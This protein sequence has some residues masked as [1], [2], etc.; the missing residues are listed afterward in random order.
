[1]LHTPTAIK[2]RDNTRRS[3]Y[4]R[5]LQFYRGDQWAAIGGSTTLAT[6]RMQR[7]RLVHNYARAFITKA[8]AYT[9]HDVR[10][11]VDAIDAGDAGNAAATSAEVALAQVAE[12]NA[13]DIL[14]LDNEISCCVLG[15]AAYKVTWSQ[16]EQRVIVTAPSVHALSVWRRADNWFQIDRV[17]QASQLSAY[18][19]LA[20]YGDLASPA[21]KS[22]YIEEWT[23][24]EYVLWVNGEAQRFPNPYGFIPFVVYPNI[25]EPGRE[26]GTSDIPAVRVPGEEYNRVMT[27]LSLIAELSGNPIAVLEGITEDTDIAIQPGAVWD[28]PAGAKAYI[29]DL[30]AAGGVRLLIDYAAE[31]KSIM[32]DLG[33]SPPAAFGQNSRG[34][35][36]VAL[37]VEL[38]PIVKKVRR[39]RLIRARAFAERAAMTLALL[40]DFAGL[41]A[42]VAAH[43]ARAQFGDV[44]PNDE[45]RNIANEVAMVNAALSSRARSMSNLGVEDPDAELARWEA[46]AARVALVQPTAAPTPAAPPAPA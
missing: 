14:D 5:N 45:Q 19:A 38:D 35:S 20:V 21:D 17:C 42:L 9:M 29:L 25:R 1:M 36:G 24:T 6:P 22:N 13:L 23:P 8:A 28:V 34:L 41:D 32:Y 16:A 31:V 30:L 4:D 10:M 7:R 3:E 33:E 2:N 18:D 12:Q 44:L 27:Q 43:P 39:K 15:D 11:V 26:W 46:E 37:N 40:R